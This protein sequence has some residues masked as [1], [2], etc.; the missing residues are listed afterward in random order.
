M[1]TNHSSNS[2]ISRLRR[3]QEVL[4]SVFSVLENSE[5]ELSQKKCVWCAQQENK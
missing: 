4:T 3:N 5:I 2:V 1:V